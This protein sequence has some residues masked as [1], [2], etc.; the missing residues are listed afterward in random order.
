MF[1]LAERDFPKRERSA[2]IMRE[3]GSDGT[4]DYYHPN[5]DEPIYKWPGRRVSE[6]RVFYDDEPTGAEQNNCINWK[7]LTTYPAVSGRTPR[8]CG[9]EDHFDYV[10][11]NVE[12]ADV[13]KPELWNNALAPFPHQSLRDSKKFQDA[14]ASVYTKHHK[15]LYRLTS[16]DLPDMTVFFAEILE[17]REIF[18]IVHGM[19]MH[20]KTLKKKLNTLQRRLK[21]LR[22]L[23]VS[24]VVR[25][26]I[27]DTIRAIQTVSADIIKWRF[28]V[29]API[30][31][32]AKIIASLGW[33]MDTIQT[34]SAKQT[35]HTVEEFELDEWWGADCLE[36]CWG[37]QC[38]QLYTT[39]LKTTHSKIKGKIIY[40]Q[41]VTN[42]LRGSAIEKVALTILGQFGMLPSIDTLWE[43]TRLSWLVDYFA[44][45][46]ILLCKLESLLGLGPKDVIVERSSLSLKFTEEQMIYGT[47]FRRG[48]GLSPS[49]VVQHEYYERVVSKDAINFTYLVP[50]WRL[51]TG[52]QITTAV[53]YFLMKTLSGVRFSW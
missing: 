49:A 42:N 2:S 46:D 52:S 20:G 10:N 13:I 30:S 3:V 31:D 23:K 15:K 11:A 43:L 5:F 38:S 45:V 48:Q 26:Q 33:F 8:A 22:R 27:R 28:G 32:L 50:Y 41:V 25:R 4:R 35:I 39:P 21:R 51:P 40:T 47:C 6:F 16:R 24:S 19:L 1:Y 44:R 37:R 29:K 12:G 7:R 14:L 36:G 34:Y 53:A 17:L 18:S 9:H